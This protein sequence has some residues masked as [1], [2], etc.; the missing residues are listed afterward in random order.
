MQDGG[1]WKTKGE[2]TFRPTYPDVAAELKEL[3]GEHVHT[4]LSVWGDYHDDSLNFQHMKASGWLV[5]GTRE[6][7]ATNPA[8]RNSFWKS[9][10]GPP[11]LFAQGWDSLWLDASEPDFG[12]HEGDALLLDKNLAIGSGA[13]LHKHFSSASHRRNCRTLE[14]NH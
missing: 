11:L 13:M 1:W 10:P 7:D 8:A 12:V 9:L 14:A 3:H 2:L 6:Y 5:P 4:M